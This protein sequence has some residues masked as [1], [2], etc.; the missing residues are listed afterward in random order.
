MATVPASMVPSYTGPSSY[1]IFSKYNN[2]AG[3]SDGDGVNKIALLDPNVTQVDPHSSANGLLEMREVFTATGPTPDPGYRSPQYPNAV[4]EWCI[5][6]A[7]VNPANNS[8]YMPSEDGNLYRWNLITNSLSQ[9]L[10]LGPAVGDPYVPTILGPD[11]TVYTMHGGTLFAVGS[12]NG[13]SI[14][15]TSS[16]P[17]DRTVVAGQSLTFS[18]A[19]A[20]HGSSG[21]TPTGT[22]TFQD[23]T[24]Q[25]LT[26]VTTNLM[27][28]SLDSSGDA[29]YTTAALGSGIHFIT[30]TYSGDANFSGGSAS[31]VQEIHASGTT[32]TLVASPATST[33]GQAVNFTATVAP[34]TSGAGTPTGMVTFE[35]GTHVLGQDALNGGTASFS[36]SALSLGS[37][38][39]TALYY[40]D[41]SDAASTSLPASVTVSSSGAQAIFVGS[42]TTTQGNWHGVY[43][44]DGYAL[45]NAGQSL[46]AYDPTFAVQNQSTWTWA[47]GT[48]DTRAL[49][50]DTQ[51]NRIAA[52]WYSASSFSFDVNFTDTNTH[53]IS[54]YLIDWDSQGRKQ[55]V[56]IIDANS[57]AVLDTENAPNPAVS[58]ANFTAGTYL[59]WNISGH[60]TIK[61]TSS[62]APNAVVSGVFFGGAGGSSAPSAVATFTGFDTSTQ[63]TWVGKYGADGYSLANVAARIPSYA[64]FTVQNQ[65]NY[66]WASSTADPRA[67]ETANASQRVAATW[68]NGSSFNF[69]LNFTDGNSH[70]FALYAVD[71]DNG[72]RS[73]TVQIVDA[74]T[75]AVLNTETISSFAG[76]TYLVWNISG[77]VKINVTTIAGFNAVVSGVFFGGGGGS[78]APSAVRYLHRL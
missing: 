65:L 23:L 76:G 14:N 2:Y 3:T 49:Q 67:L 35:E 61:V 31:L 38:S 69:D 62:G 74:N 58:S 73:E 22:I 16:V 59:I 25:G 63:G 33:P 28:V 34:V 47:T 10:A 51:G 60:I 52:T 50:T 37:H 36:T 6:T 44:A 43:G 53:Q 1:L 5:N 8:V 21:I 70:K 26:P 30:A 24:Y 18:V 72:G 13:A 42:D 68:Y 56:Q 71:W 29:S 27:T 77:H 32:T 4:L 11:G 9:S 64:S 54:L 48:T 7:A 40:S 75:N 39:I 55:T 45:A 41:S 66:T 46:P 15:I 19:V 12:L 20:N 17:D 57:S 78:S